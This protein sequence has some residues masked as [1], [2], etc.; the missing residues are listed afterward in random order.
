MLNRLDPTDTI[1]AIATPAGPGLLGMVRVTGPEARSIALDGFVGDEFEP[2]SRA[3]RR[4]GRL[5]IDGLGPALPVSV[6]YWPGPRT[7]TGQP[8]AE[9]A[10]PG[11]SPILGCL[12]SHYL[13]RGARL[14]EPGNSRSGPS[15]RVGSTSLSRKPCWG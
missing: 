2:S 5:R 7:Y 9:I 10:A 12:L 13:N 6:A 3:E 4:R 14:A 1:A 8:L 15:S 11:S